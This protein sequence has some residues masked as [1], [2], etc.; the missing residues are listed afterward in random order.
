[1][2]LVMAPALRCRATGGK[3][4]PSLCHGV[5]ICFPLSSWSFLAKWSFSSWVMLLLS[6]EA[7]LALELLY[8][9]NFGASALSLPATAKLLDCNGRAMAALC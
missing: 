1:M 3:S 9:L 7:G 6:S 8:W 2:P 5:L 4:L